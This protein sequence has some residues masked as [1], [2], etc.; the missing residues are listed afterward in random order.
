MIGKRPKLDL[1]LLAPV[2]LID[3]EECKV[4]QAKVCFGGKLLQTPRYD[5]LK[6]PVGYR[7]EGP[8]LFEQSDTTI[9]LEPGMVSEV[10]RFGNLIIIPQVP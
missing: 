5:R 2:S 8:A 6:L 7:V 4:G 10:D 3:V 9:F 1:T